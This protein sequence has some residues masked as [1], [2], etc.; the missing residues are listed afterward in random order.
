MWHK[1]K[2]L[3][4]VFVLSACGFEPLYVERQSGE[5]WYYKGEFDTSITEEIAQ[6]KV[7]PIADRIGQ[8]VR[9]DLLDSFTP[10]GMPDKPKYRL[11]ITNIRKDTAKQAMRD[12]ITATRERVEYHLTYT[13]FDASSGEKLVSGDT[14][15]LLGYD[16]M[17]NPYSTTFSLKKI[18]KDA[19]KI[20]AND[21]SLRIGAYFHSVLTKRG[22][23]NEL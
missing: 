5:K 8:M 22:N 23:P 19:A 14:L 1:L 16:I 20:M 2:I 3:S 15:A 13:M 21:I 10:K 11:E 18:E 17:A 9:N 4:L 7:E 6:I 12:D